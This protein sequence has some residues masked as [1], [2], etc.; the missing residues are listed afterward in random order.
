MA[1]ASASQRRCFTRKLEGQH[2][3]HRHADHKVESYRVQ[4]RR[5]CGARVLLRCRIRRGRFRSEEHTS[6]L[7]S[8]RHL[9]CRLLLEKKKKKSNNARSNMNKKKKA[10]VPRTVKKNTTRHAKSPKSTRTS[11]DIHP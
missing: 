8:L 11:Q 9:V 3:K 2:R 6:E 4:I 7:Q 5:Y 1:A 10:N